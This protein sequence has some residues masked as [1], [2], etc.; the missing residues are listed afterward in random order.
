MRIYL[1]SLDKRRTFFY[2][3]ESEP[4]DDCTGADD[5]CGE[6]TG[7]RARL[8]EQREQFRSVWHESDARVVR[9]SRRAWEWMHSWAHPDETMLRRL[10]SACRIE[11]H[12]PAGRDP[13]EVSGLWSR[14]LAQRWWRHLLWLSVN[15]AV[16]PPAVMALWVLPGPNVIGYWFAYRAIHHAMIVRGIRRARWGGLPVVLRALP[17]LDQPIERDD[18]GRAAHPAIDGPAPLLSEHVAR[19][20]AEA[21]PIQP[22]SDEPRKQPKP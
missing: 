6:E 19:T 2:A 8:R 15:L 10:R 3:D 1:L 11:L 18:E 17:S 9:W 20:E 16:A 13:E 5:S 14:Y 12:H 4:P 22:P 21:A 7:W